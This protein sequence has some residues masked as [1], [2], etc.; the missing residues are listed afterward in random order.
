MYDPG[1][2]QRPRGFGEV[3]QPPRCMLIGHYLERLLACLQRP[4]RELNIKQLKHAHG[5]AVKLILRRPEG[6]SSY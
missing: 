1:R 4:G 5:Q 6:I 3:S 2:A